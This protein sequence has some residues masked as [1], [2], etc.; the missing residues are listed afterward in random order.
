VKKSCILRRSEGKNFILKELSGEEKLE[1][2]EER[3]NKKVKSGC[4]TVEFPKKKKKK[5]KKP[6]YPTSKFALGE[7][8]NKIK[9]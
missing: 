5:K 1:E 3:E 6:K 2:S 8:K 4:K 9:N 7:E